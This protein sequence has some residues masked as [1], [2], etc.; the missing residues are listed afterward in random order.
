MVGTPM[1]KLKK[2]IKIKQWTVQ[3]YDPKCREKHIHLN[4]NFTKY[5]NLPIVNKYKYY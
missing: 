1:I 4:L 2:T 5:K 3:N